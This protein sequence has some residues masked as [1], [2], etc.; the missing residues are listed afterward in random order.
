LRVQVIDLHDLRH[1]PS[2]LPRE[3]QRGYL[4]NQHPK[5]GQK[6]AVNDQKQEVEETTFQGLLVFIFTKNTKV[7]IAL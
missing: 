7:L 2:T 3:G 4:K 6:R 1:W 5:H